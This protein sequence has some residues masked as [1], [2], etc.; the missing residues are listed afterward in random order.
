MLA[1]VKF[2]VKE[3][4][5]IASFVIFILSITGISIYGN[6]NEI[7][8]WK[9]SEETVIEEIEEPD[10]MPQIKIIE[11]TIETRVESGVT[12]QQVKIIIDAVM[13]S[14]IKEFH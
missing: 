6:V 3:H 12:D 13:E 10:S 5:A 9:S 14:H 7:N 8:P 4:K 11:K 2:I 1:W